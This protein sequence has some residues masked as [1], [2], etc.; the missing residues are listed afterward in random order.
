MTKINRWRR[1]RRFTWLFLGIVRD[2]RREAKIA[3]RVGGQLARE[4]MSKRHRKRAIKFR[5]TAIE[6]GGVLIKLGQ[7]FSARVDIM[8]DEYIQE[9]AKL[10]DTVPPAPFEKVKEV[11]ETDFKQPLEKIF[12]SF[13]TETLAAASLAQVYKAEL[14]TGEKVAVKVLRPGI[15]ELIDID[16][17]TF[18]Y[19]MEG[20]HR[21]TSFGNRTDIPMVVGEFIRTLGDELD[22]YREGINAVR[23][24]RMFA[25]DEFIHIPKIYPDY[26]S[27]HV[28][29]LEAI[30]GLKISNYKE[31]ESQ[32]IDRHLVATEVF[33]SYLK[34]VLEEGFFHADPHPG[35]LFVMEGPVVAFV[36][37]GMVG[38]ITPTMQKSLRA[39]IIGIAKKDAVVIVEA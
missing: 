36:D 9:L 19:L 38:E 1:I 30:N 20:V 29:T 31:L 16:L 25:D 7:F 8:P 24:Q 32:G 5:E 39:G 18:A 11:I 34:Q 22:F 10:Q 33:N 15:E 14:K 26:S 35:N 12:K 21:F 27:S 6:M 37:F 4:R 13:D 3:A 23:F 2:F 17:A 28:L